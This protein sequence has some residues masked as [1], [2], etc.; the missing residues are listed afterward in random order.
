MTQ[1]DQGTMHTT[2]TT[3]TIDRVFPTR[4]ERLWQAWTDPELVRQWLAPGPM[5]CKVARYEVRKGGRWRLELSGP[6]PG[7]KPMHMVYEGT[8]DEV[9]PGKRIVMLW[10]PAMPSV[11]PGPDDPPSVVTIEFIP[12]PGG[13]RL[14]LT[15]D[16]MP[17]K[18]GAGHAGMG[19]MSSFEKLA[20]MLKP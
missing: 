2:E 3:V 6:G 15:Q 8:F 5:T 17:N 1:K 14:R 12:V 9:T 19:W 7:G 16:G 10:P 18:E 20:R 4:P 13:T 11:E